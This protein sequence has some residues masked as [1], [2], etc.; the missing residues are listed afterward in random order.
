MYIY[1]WKQWLQKV[2]DSYQNFQMHT[3]ENYIEA[4]IEWDWY[5]LNFNRGKL[6][7]YFYVK[8]IIFCET[9]INSIIEFIEKKQILI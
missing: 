2:T 6:S 8:T 4:D 5:G 7:V 3:K 9:D 1:A